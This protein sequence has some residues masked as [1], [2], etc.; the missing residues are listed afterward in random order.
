MA[1]R[2]GSAYLKNVATR[3][4]GISRRS[5]YYNRNEIVVTRVTIPY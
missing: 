5:P 1:V 4:L 3:L 2:N